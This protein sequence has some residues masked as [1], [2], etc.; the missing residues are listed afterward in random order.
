MIK[1]DFIFL[2][3]FLKFTFLMLNYSRENSE[4]TSFQTVNKSYFNSTLK[5]F[6]SQ[7]CDTSRNFQQKGHLLVSKFRKLF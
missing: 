2:S 1:I 5:P 3:D 7:I 6:Y 4:K